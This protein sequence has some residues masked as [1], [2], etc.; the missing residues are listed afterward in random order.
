MRSKIT[1]K[2]VNETDDKV[3]EKVNL[4]ADMNALDSW[5]EK[6][7]NEEIDAMVEKDIKFFDLLDDYF[8]YKPFTVG[9]EMVDKYNSKDGLFIIE[10]ISEG[11]WSLFCL[12]RDLNKKAVDVYNT[13][14]DSSDK[15]NT[16]LE[17]CFLQYLRIKLLS[18]PK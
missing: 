10:N 9:D 15:H 2:I 3:K 6:H 7:K 11:R 14:L 5:L 18:F 1:H 16:S 4:Y 12:S 13:V 17:N 8:D